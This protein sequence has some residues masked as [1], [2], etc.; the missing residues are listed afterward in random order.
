M[1]MELVASQ[2]VLCC[3][4]TTRT[5]TARFSR[6]TQE[7]LSVLDLTLHFLPLLLTL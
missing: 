3:V 5:H 7:E 4:D 1:K 6:H 2:S